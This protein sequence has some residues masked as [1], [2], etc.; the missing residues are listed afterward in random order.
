MLEFVLSTLA[1]IRVFFRSRSDTALEILALRQ[2]LAVLKPPTAASMLSGSPVLDH[3][4]TVL[5][6]LGRSPRHRQAQHRCR[7]ASNRIPALLA[8]ALSPGLW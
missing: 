5:V 8:L 7:L 2:Q 6:A 4:A 1:V 3:T